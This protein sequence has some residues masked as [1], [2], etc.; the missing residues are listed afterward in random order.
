MH[1]I[2]YLAPSGEKKYCNVV[3]KCDSV[4][5]IFYKQRDV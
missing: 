2:D 5:H 1:L 4:P 3:W